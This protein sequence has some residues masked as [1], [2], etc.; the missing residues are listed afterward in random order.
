MKFPD[1]IGFRLTAQEAEALATLAEYHKV[2]PHQYARTILQA[3]LEQ[4]NAE[5]FT[6]RI[7]RVEDGIDALRSDIAETLEA[8]LVVVGKQP[9][10]QIREYITRKFRM[11]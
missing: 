9:P 2:S 7:S 10:E 3:H 6:E 4:N 1:Q 11:R 5:H 8:L